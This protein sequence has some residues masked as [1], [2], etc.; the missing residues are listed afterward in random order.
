MSFGTLFRPWPENKNKNKTKA[1][2]KNNKVKKITFVRNLAI[3]APLLLE[4]F[5]A[6]WVAQMV[7][8]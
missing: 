8:N 5:F 2:A 1:K 7:L 4:S 3:T 6:V